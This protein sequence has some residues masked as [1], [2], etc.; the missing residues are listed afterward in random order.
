MSLLERTPTSPLSGDICMTPTAPAAAAPPHRDRPRPPALPPVVSFYKKVGRRRARACARAPRAM[1][2]PSR[3]RRRGWTCEIM[4]T[5]RRQLLVGSSNLSMLRV[6]ISPK[7]PGSS[8]DRTLGEWTTLDLREPAA[9]LRSP[10]SSM[11]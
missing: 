1:T 5:D 6:E 4:I 10:P 9:Q 8:L 7:T 11:I 2:R 3:P